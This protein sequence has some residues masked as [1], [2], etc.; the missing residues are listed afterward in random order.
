MIVV[1]LAICGQ[2]HA[3]TFIIRDGKAVGK[4]LIPAE[5]SAEIKLAADELAQH[6]EKVS[7]AR[8]EIAHDAGGALPAG[9]MRLSV[10]AD[11]PKRLAR[12][13]GEQAFVI[14]QTGPGIVIEG[15]S[16]LAVLYGVYEY[17]S[18]LGV[19]W[20]AP[21]ELGTH[22]PSRASIAI[23]GKRK[24]IQ[25]AFRIRFIWLN[26]NPDWHLEAKTPEQLM[27]N[28]IDY[29]YWQLR[30]RMQFSYRAP[31]KGTLPFPLTIHSIH[32]VFSH[33][34]SVIYRWKKL[35]LEKN[36]ERFPLV[37][38]DGKKVRIDKG[39]ICF[40]HPDNIADATA[41][42][43]DYFDQNPS[44]ITASM[45]LQ[46]TGGV[47]ECDECTKANGG[48]SPAERCDQLV[49]SF[50]NEVAR[51]IAEKRPDRGIGFFSSYG[52]TSMPLP[53][54]KVQ[55][56]ILGVVC[57]IDH[58]NHDLNDAACPNNQLFLRQ[59]AALKAT[60]AECA[61][62][63]YTT[64]P[65]SLQPLIILDYV[66]TYHKLGLKGYTCET[67]ARSAQHTMVTWAQ[68]QLAWNI[69]Q[70]PR[71]LIEE[72]CHTYFGD[73]GVDVLAVVD[74]VDANIRKLPKL[75][76]SGYG[77]SQEIMTDDVIALGRKRMEQA[78]GKVSGVYAQRLTR[79]RDTIE[80][81]S[82]LAEA[83]RALYVT[84]DERTPA[85]QKA[86]VQK[87]DDAEAYWN[88][89]NLAQSCSPTILPGWIERVKR[90]AV[91]LPTINTAP[92]K[93]LIDA[94]EAT[95]RRELF[96][97]D[98]VPDKLE[99]LTFLPSHWKFHIDIARRGET[100]GWMQPTFDDSKWISLGNNFFDDQGFQRYEGTF[101]YR[102][103]FDVPAVPSGKRVIMRFGAL[104]DDGKIYLNG[105]LAHERFH[106][107][108]NDWMRSFEFDATE[109][110][111]SGQKNSVAICGRNDYGKGGLWKPAA[112]YF[113]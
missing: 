107:M 92:A 109:F 18:D 17:L 70:E 83:Y 101:W 55:G 22:V 52:A 34:I 90:T 29:A 98:K 24:Q 27:Q 113:R 50:M 100:E 32:D 7:G 39:Q 64:F 8:L 91:T 11:A 31:R 4:I 106:V 28:R 71:K 97:L 23:N 37:T 36:P 19:R 60:G 26:G 6:L 76:L 84:L 3:E 62:Y 57:H 105:E 102:T 86:A 103:A 15:K 66:K 49:W 69:D 111:K 65:A 108:G 38:R 46:D 10:A 74:A 25:P 48:V 56:N 93:I 82:R 67:M 13:G 104:D 20:F 2:S 110:I 14:D 73:A 43:L 47:C 35:S 63:D 41:W 80:L 30:N 61:A 44:M 75:T 40:T 9:T 79:F 53:G 78:A 95:L 45:A 96:S 72:Y 112:I 42:C 16:D 58:N 54:T 99:G 87:F 77:A 89:H 1:G 21:G 5:A 85:N 94:D 88:E 59:I 33:N 12:D 68:A 81:Y 51:R